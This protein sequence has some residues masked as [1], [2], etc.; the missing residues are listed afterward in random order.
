M[1]LWNKAGLLFVSGNWLW[2]SCVNTNCWQ[3]STLGKQENPH[4]GAL[5][6]EPPTLLL[7]ALSSSELITISQPAAV[8]ERHTMKVSPKAGH[9]PPNQPFC[10]FYSRAV[11]S[12]ATVWQQWNLMSWWP[13]C[14]GLAGIN[15]NQTTASNA[16][17]IRTWFKREAK[18]LLMQV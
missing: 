9:V 7:R 6:L 11:M 14:C 2:W 1:H 5:I 12:F 4:P 3:C 16:A 17:C 10:Q 15:I 13:A 8:I 18:L